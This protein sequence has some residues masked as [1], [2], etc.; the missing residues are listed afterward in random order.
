MSRNFHFRTATAN[1]AL[2]LQELIQAAF[3]VNDEAN[4]DWVGSPEFAD[5]FS[6]ELDVIISR[7]TA[8]DGRFL[9]ASEAED[10]HII[11]CVNVFRKTP[12]FGRLGL[13]AVDPTLQ[14]GG[15]GKIILVHGEKYLIQELGVSTIGLNTLHTRKD[16]IK[17][18]ERQGYVKTGKMTKLPVERFGTDI[19]ARI[20]LVEFEKNVA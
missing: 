5:A 6:I 17:W 3:R 9:V 10:G 13:I 12:K 18:Y 14:R 16:M 15:L 8:P 11:G 1:D 4:I 19:S 2:R 7:I 20:G